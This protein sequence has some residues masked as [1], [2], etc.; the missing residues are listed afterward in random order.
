MKRSS[1]LAALALAMQAPAVARAGTVQGSFN[2]HSW[3]ASNTLVGQT[4]TGGIHGG[5]DPL[6]FATGPNYN[7]VVA[8][9]MQ[10]PAGLF[11]CS[12]ALLPGRLSVL[13]AGH[14]VSSGA[15]TATPIETTAWFYGG[16]PDVR[17]P[18]DP[19][20]VSI[21]VTDYFVN[22]S[23]TGEVIDQ[24]DIAVV[25]LGRAAPDWVQ[26]HGLWLGDDLTGAGFNVAGYGSRSDAGGAVG[27]NSR[28]GF[29]RQGDNGY[30]FRWGDPDWGGFDWNG[31]LFDDP[32]HPGAAQIDYSYVSDF[33]S[34]NSAN[35]AACILAADFGL[36][37]PKFCGVGVGATE[38]GVAGGDSGGPEFINGL[39]ASVTGYGLSF[40]SGHGDIDD[41]LNSSWGEFSGYVPVFLHADFIN[42]SMAPEPSTWAMMITGLGF[43]G[44][45]VRRRT[46]RLH[47]RA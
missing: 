2:G 11:I 38:V 17:T 9:I 46:A 32:A 42:A 16:D 18:F 6:Y 5:G 33:D 29:L 31:L 27:A 3:Q 36:G 34:G 15:G 41:L 45:P 37:G 7:G 35:D 43:M 40:G 21:K 13:T 44:W 20:G 47:R 19:A 25:R 23:Y 10:E 4:S 14:C 8:L 22:P 26:S 24:N 30:A 28:T 12:G 1:T 39:I